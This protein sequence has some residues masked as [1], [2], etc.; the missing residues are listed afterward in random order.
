MPRAPVSCVRLVTP[1]RPKAVRKTYGPP[2]TLEALKAEVK[3]TREQK[4]DSE[5]RAKVKQCDRCECAGEPATI[6]DTSGS[7]VV[8]LCAEHY[9]QREARLLLDG[10][11]IRWGR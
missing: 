7:R 9:A 10:A 6:I 11:R 8:T 1:K 5:L 4:E 3:P 2:A